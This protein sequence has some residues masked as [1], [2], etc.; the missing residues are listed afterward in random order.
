MILLIPLFELTIDSDA[1]LALV[2]LCLIS[3]LELKS[4]LNKKNVKP[5]YS[6]RTTNFVG[7]LKMI[8]CL[9]RHKRANF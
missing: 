9:G 4:A 1:S 5:P 8:K 7:R 6:K 3:I 2:F